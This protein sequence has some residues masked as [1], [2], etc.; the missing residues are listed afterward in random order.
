MTAAQGI[1]VESVEVV[2]VENSPHD[3]RLIREAFELWS[4]PYH[5]SCYSD[6]VAAMRDLTKRA[7]EGALRRVLMLLDWNLPGVHGSKILREIRADARFKNIYVVVFT[8]SSSALDQELA[9]KL[10][11]DRFVTKAVD[12]DDFFYALVS[13]QEV[14]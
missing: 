12:I 5:L 9:R 2:V 10:G 7:Q 13:L 1:Q 3:T 14:L 11:A 6:G 4:R 8:S